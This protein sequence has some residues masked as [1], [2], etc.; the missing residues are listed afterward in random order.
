MNPKQKLT[1]KPTTKAWKP[2]IGENFF[3]INFTKYRCEIN[4]GTRGSVSIEWQLN[5][6]LGN[7]FKTR[8]VALVAAKAIRTLLKTLDHG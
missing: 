7:Y 8:K 5:G 2:E 6:W 3:F 4:V 1:S